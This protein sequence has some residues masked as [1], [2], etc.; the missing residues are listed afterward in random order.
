MKF[1][2]NV[3]L[4]YE[5]IATKCYVCYSEAVTSETEQDVGRGPSTCYSVNMPL[6][7][8]RL[9]SCYN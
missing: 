6:T 4:N 8:F 3:I 5:L 2:H 7:K 9:P 1:M